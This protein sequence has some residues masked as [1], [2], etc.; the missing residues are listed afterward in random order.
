MPRL[1]AGDQRECPRLKVPPMYTLVRV[2]PVGEKR[3]RWLGYVHDVSEKG[4][5]FELDCPLPPGSEVEVRAM[6][7]GRYHMTFRAKGRVVRIH[8]D[9]EF[10]GPMRM[11]MIFDEFPRPVDLERLT[12][13]L[14]LAKPA[15]AA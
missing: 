13:Y 9:L 11:A 4:M 5:R 12:M 8:D 14:K 6:L 1:D 15:L 7:P 10:Q 3:Y 2:R